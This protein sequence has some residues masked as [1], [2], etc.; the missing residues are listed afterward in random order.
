MLIASR[1]GQPASRLARIPFLTSPSVKVVYSSAARYV[2]ALAKPNTFLS[3]SN[4]NGSAPDP[5][6]E[7]CMRIATPAS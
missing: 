2:C 4:S 7:Y 1:T 3:G 6:E 5:E